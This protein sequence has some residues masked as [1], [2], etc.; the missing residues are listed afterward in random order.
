[1]SP[2]GQG[3]LGCSEGSSSGMFEL[4]ECS[5]S[6]SIGLEFSVCSVV[7]S[8]PTIVTGTPPRK[9]MQWGVSGVAI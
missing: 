6:S 1:M 5:V 9:L 4:L 3:L 8:D 2:I 7:Y